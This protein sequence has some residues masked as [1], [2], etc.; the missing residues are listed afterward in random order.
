MSFATIFFDFSGPEEGEEIHR[1]EWEDAW[2][3]QDES[4]AHSELHTI[5]LPSMSI[6]QH[7]VDN[8][9]ASRTTKNMLTSAQPQ[10]DVVAAPEVV[11][12]P[13]RSLA[14]TTT[15]TAPITPIPVNCPD[16]TWTKFTY[17]LVQDD[18]HHTGASSNFD[19]QKV[20]A[21]SCYKVIQ[22]QNAWTSQM[23]A[24]VQGCL[25]CEKLCEDEGGTLVTITEENLEF[26]A[27]LTDDAVKPLKGYSAAACVG[28]YRGWSSFKRD[29]FWI[30]EELTYQQVV[31]GG[32]TTT[33]GSPVYNLTGTGLREKAKWVD[34][35]V[36]NPR[37]G[38]G[39]PQDCGFMYSGRMKRPGRLYNVPCKP[40]KSFG[41]R[42]CICQSPGRPHL[43][44]A[45][46]KARLEATMDMSDGMDKFFYDT[47]TFYLPLPFCGL[48]GLMLLRALFGW[49]CAS[50]R[51]T[52]TIAGGGSAA[53]T[54]Q[55]QAGASVGVDHAGESQ[56]ESGTAEKATPANIQASSSHEQEQASG[57]HYEAVQILPGLRFFAIWPLCLT[58]RSICHDN[59]GT[60]RNVYSSTTPGT[61]AGVD[62]SGPGVAIGAPDSYNYDD[63]HPLTIN[64]AEHQ[65]SASPDSGCCNYGRTCLIFPAWLCSSYCLTDFSVRFVWRLLVAVYFALRA[66]LLAE[67][68][69][70]V[71]GAYYVGMGVVSLVAHY[72]LGR[73]LVDSPDRVRKIL[74]CY[75][76]TASSGSAEQAP[77]IGTV[78]R[79]LLQSW[80][81][82]LR[83]A[84]RRMV[85]RRLLPVL[86]VRAVYFFI[87]ERF[88][89]GI[90]TSVF[91]FGALQPLFWLLAVLSL[92]S[93][94]LCEQ[95]ERFVLKRIEGCILANN[96]QFNST[97]GGTTTWTTSKES[98]T[99]GVKKEELQALST[100]TASS[101]ANDSFLSRSSSPPLLQVFADHFKRHGKMMEATRK[102]F[103]TSIAVCFG[104]LTV[105][106]LCNLL[107]ALTGSPFWMAQLVIWFVLFFVFMRLLS[108][109][110][111]AYNTALQK[112][113]E[114]LLFVTATT[115]TGSTYSGFTTTAAGALASSN[116][117]G[118]TAT[119]PVDF[120]PAAPGGAGGVSGGGQHFVG[121]QQQLQHYAN[122]VPPTVGGTMRA[123][124]ELIVKTMEDR[125]V[126]KQHT[127]VLLGS[128]ITADV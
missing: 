43:K 69:F 49:L 118:T 99:S 120:S 109:L 117:A 2:A 11:V 111:D 125:L 119:V 45:H 26:V 37:E 108:R 34:W 19:V 122:I 79:H 103:G 89:G 123:N 55:K 41:E 110:G 114:L 51:G 30:R 48:F 54:K 71:L 128:P 13:R 84:Q 50:R 106:L 4:D 47:A 64:T 92:T 15:Q 77:F 22:T 53:S 91:F 21:E 7:Q 5:Q 63:A 14:A 1:I 32:T 90:Q 46:D 3:P 66:F 17:N 40:Y 88:R 23:G 59:Y 42:E 121:P 31:G 102:V 115:T 52:T 28:L 78:Q 81:E 70:I 20:V 33:V 67:E 80:P 116:N 8:N 85:T 96:S 124:L 18:T 44:W 16:N 56:K 10:V 113:R 61:N 126:M 105:G 93:D 29:W 97:T 101:A 112:I 62:L 24:G 57:S 95:L 73:V 9:R 58:V 82:R 76:T 25:Y 27:K 60:A 6:I 39:I 74:A 107:F 86:L 72:T 75:S 83:Q 127:W 35:Q 36:G 12:D 98:K 68:G 94:A 104:T 87:Q 38:A 100:T 65:L